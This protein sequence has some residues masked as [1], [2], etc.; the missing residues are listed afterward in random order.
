MSAGKKS[1][2]SEVV[3]HARETP[4][5]SLRANLRSRGVFIPPLLPRVGW[6][7]PV[8]HYPIDASSTGEHEAVAP[9]AVEPVRAAAVNPWKSPV[10]SPAH[11]FPTAGYDPSEVLNE[12]AAVVG[13]PATAQMEKGQAS[14]LVDATRASEHDSPST[15]RAQQRYEQIDLGEWGFALLVSFI[16]ADAK[17][18][19]PVERLADVRQELGEWLQRE[20][21]QPEL[22][23][24]GGDYDR[25]IEQHLI[26][27]FGTRMHSYPV[28]TADLAYIGVLD[29]ED[30]GGDDDATPPGPVDVP[31]E[32]D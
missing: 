20:I 10:S 11:H 13:E 17:D 7:P 1:T 15:S 4:F 28:V 29:L 31:M 6:E 5:I 23:G 8:V 21:T 22:V 12:E 9:A 19:R 16:S 30:V 2:F 3:V 14:A 18:P 27:F 24:T 32:F 25:D 26:R